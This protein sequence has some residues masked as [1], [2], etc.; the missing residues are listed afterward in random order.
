M[1]AEGVMHRQEAMIEEVL[2]RC[3]KP[4]PQLTVE[5]YSGLAAPHDLA[6]LPHFWQHVVSPESGVG[7]DGAHPPRLP[8]HLPSRFR[9][10]CL[11]WQFGRE[12]LPLA[13]QASC[14]ARRTRVDGA[15]SLT[16]PSIFKGEWLH[17]PAPTAVSRRSFG[18]AT[19]GFRSAAWAGR[20][21][22]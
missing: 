14:Q 11:A 4:A 18:S 10:P 12:P 15:K 3:C 9:G 22:P 1:Q 8:C 2:K 16:F 19:A 7:T 17:G 21:L 5:R 20:A 6:Q 13:A